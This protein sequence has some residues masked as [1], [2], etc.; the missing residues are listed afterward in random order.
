MLLLSSFSFYSPPPLTIPFSFWKF[1]FFFPGRKSKLKKN[2]KKRRKMD[3]WK[4][5]KDGAVDECRTF[6]F[7]YNFFF[8]FLLLRVVAWLPM[9]LPRWPESFLF[10][11]PTSWPLPLWCFSPPVRILQIVCTIFRNHVAGWY[12]VCWLVQ[13]RQCGFVDRTD[14]VI[15]DPNRKITNFL[16][17]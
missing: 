4:F 7:L 5:L 9:M 10:L 3:A 17:I 12:P 6:Y 8:Y 13:F 11:L 1:F 2:K 14:F 15:V 16:E